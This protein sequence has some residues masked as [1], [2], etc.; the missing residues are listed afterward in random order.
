MDAVPLYLLAYYLQIR[1]H[2]D[3]VGYLERRLKGMDLAHACDEQAMILELVDL[4]LIGVAKKEVEIT[5]NPLVEEVRPGCV[6]HRG[7]TEHTLR[8]PEMFV[9]FAR[10][11]YIWTELLAKFVGW[12]ATA[13]VCGYAGGL[14]VD[15]KG[16]HFDAWVVAVLVSLLAAFLACVCLVL[17]TPNPKR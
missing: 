5:Y 2:A 11:R 10:G 12:L 15:A 13:I 1:Q 7:G 9:I 6:I 3:E 8:V 14:A 4:H 17:T 16:Q